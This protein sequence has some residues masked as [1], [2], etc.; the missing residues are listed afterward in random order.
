MEVDHEQTAAPSH[1]T[2]A[3]MA[4]A[5][6]GEAAPTPSKM[7]ESVRVDHSSARLMDSAWCI[8]EEPGTLVDNEGNVHNM[9]EENCA[10]E[11]TFRQQLE[12]PIWHVAAEKRLGK[13]LQ[14]GPNHN[15]VR[16]V[17]ASYLAAGGRADAH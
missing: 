16:K 4:Q 3:S 11:H 10:F 8:S 13:G 9:L 14:T 15:P 6:A 1:I 12:Q 17:R 7:A 5:S 2:E